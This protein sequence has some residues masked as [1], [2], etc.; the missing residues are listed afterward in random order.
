MQGADVD[1]RLLGDAPTCAKDLIYFLSDRGTL[2]GDDVDVLADA[3]NDVVHGVADPDDLIA[4]RPRATPT[5]R[6]RAKRKAAHAARK[7]NRQG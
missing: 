6:R 3:T 4:G 5:P 1:N 7:H 2:T